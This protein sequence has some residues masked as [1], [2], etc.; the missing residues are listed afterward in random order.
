MHI[1]TVV[2]RVISQK[3]AVQNF[4]LW[5]LQSLEILF[6]GV[7]TGE[8]AG[9]GNSDLVHGFASRRHPSL[10]PPTLRLSLNEK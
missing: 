3:T 6:N 4:D 1:S 8:M 10:L 9:T 5:L 7:R 2:I